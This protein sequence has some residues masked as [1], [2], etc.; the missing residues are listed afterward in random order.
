[1]K[2]CG[3][4]QARPGGDDSFPGCFFGKTL[5]GDTLKFRYRQV[6]TNLEISVRMNSKQTITSK[7]KPIMTEK[8]V[9][10]AGMM[11]LTGLSNETVMRA[12]DQRIE[13]CSLR[14]LATIAGALGV[15]TKDLYEEE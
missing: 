11:T 12:R 4:G 3:V 15:R 7:V 14:T 5:V 10:V 8:N 1:M 6:K 2:G 13:S 9:T